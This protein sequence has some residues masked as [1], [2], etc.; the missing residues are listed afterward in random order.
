[1]I[2]TSL[3]IGSSSILQ[4]TRTAIKSWMSSNSGQIGLSPSENFTCSWVAKKP[5]FD[6]VQSIVPSILI[7]SSSDLQVT[8][9]VHKFSDEFEFRRDQTIHFGVTCPWEPKKPI[10]ERVWLIA[11]SFWS[12]VLQSCRLQGQLSNFGPDLTIFFGVTCPWAMKNFP[13]Y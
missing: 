6:L 7:E 8:G 10:V 9:A 5:I 3:L 2:A 4:V 11:T 1:M 12:E 13:I